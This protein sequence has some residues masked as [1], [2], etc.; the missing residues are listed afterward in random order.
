MPVLLISLAGFEERILRGPARTTGTGSAA[1]SYDALLLHSMAPHG[2]T[3]S[4]RA[5]P[6]IW[7]ELLARVFVW[8]EVRVKG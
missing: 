2:E 4:A 6:R 5:W 3:R 7:T 8:A 1:A